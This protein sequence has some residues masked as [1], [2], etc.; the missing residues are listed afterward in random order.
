MILQ[1]FCDILVGSLLHDGY[2]N[3][4]NPRYGT[5]MKENVDAAHKVVSYDV[6]MDAAT[7]MK[8]AL[9]KYV[10]DDF[11][12]ARICLLKKNC[13]ED[14]NCGAGEESKRKEG[15]KQY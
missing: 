4:I 13:A 5:V 11:E 9:A 14:G 10:E 12:F 6:L 8:M 7:R 1:E 3:T 15:S 2:W